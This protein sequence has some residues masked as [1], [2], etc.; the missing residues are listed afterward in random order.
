MT[1]PVGR[2]C[3]T[4]AR[5]LCLTA[6]TAAAGAAFSAVEA[7]PEVRAPASGILAVAYT[8]A[9]PTDAATG[10]CVF[11]GATPDRGAVPAT[12]V[13][14]ALPPTGAVLVV[15]ETG[16]QGDANTGDGLCDRDAGTAGNQCTL[17]AAIQQANTIAG[18][19]TIQFSIGSGPQTITPFG[20]YPDITSPVLIDG[21][22]QPGFAGTPIVELNGTFVTGSNGL[23]VNVGGST[24]TGL[25]INRFGGTGI[26]LLTVGGNT[27]VGNYI[28]TDITGTVD[29]GNGGN[30]VYVSASGNVVGGVT[31]A[32][33]NLI[34]GNQAAAVVLLTG[35]GAPNNNTIQGNYTGTDVTGTLPLGNLNAGILIINGANNLIG[36]TAGTSTTSC[37][38]ACNLVADTRVNASVGPC[39]VS[40][41]IFG[42]AATGNR[43]EGNYVGTDVTGSVAMGSAACDGVRLDQASG[44]TVG[45]TSPGARNII[46]DHPGHGVEIRGVGGNNNLVQGNYIGTDDT[47]MVAL[48]NAGN[49][50]SINATSGN[51]I[52]GSV[53]TARNI[54]SGNTLAGVRIAG[55]GATGNNVQANYIG[56]QPDGATALANAG[57]GV[58]ITDTASNNMIGGTVAGVA[59]R[60]AHNGGDG[61][62]IESGTGNGVRR[63]SIFANAGLGLDLG[64]DGELL[65]D[66]GDAD[67]GANNRQNYPILTN[68]S[69]PGP[70]P[71]LNGFLNSAPGTA[72]TIEFFSTDASE[73]SPLGE[74]H[75][76][77]DSLAVVTDGT[78]KASFSYALAVPVS[79]GEFVTATATDGAN[80]TSEISHDADMDALFD[81]WEVS[82]IDGNDNGTPDLILAGANPLHRDLYL[83]V[84]SMIERGIRQP[85]LARVVLAFAAA[86]QAFIHNPDQA[87]GVALHI[88]YDETNVTRFEFPNVWTEFNLIKA[89]ASTSIAGGFGTVTQRGDP[90][91]GA[92]LAAKKMAYRYAI[93][94]DK[95]GATASSGRAE[96]NGNDFMVTL[97]GWVKPGGTADQ[98]AGTFMHEFGHTLGLLHGGNQDGDAGNAVRWNYK[99]NYH[100]VMNYS[101]QTPDPDSV[102]WSLDYSRSVFPSLNEAALNEATGIGGHPGHNAPIGPVGLVRFV[103][104]SGPVD[105]SDDGDTADAG[106]VL[107]INDFDS[108]Y[109]ASPGDVLTGY[110]DWSNL[111]YFFRES[112]GFADGVNSPVQA[113]E[114][115]TDAF[116]SNEMEVL[117][118]ATLIDD[119][120]I[121][122][123]TP[124]GTVFGDVQLSGGNVIHTFTVTN[125]G[126][127][128]L[129]LT[130]SPAVQISGPNAGDFS[131]VQQPSITSLAP[132]ASTTFKVRFAPSVLGG[133]SATISMP[134]TDLDANP[135]D[136]AI[137][138]NGTP[139]LDPDG[140]GIFDAADNCP[141]NANPLQENSDRNFIDQT[142]PSTQDDRT[143][144]RSDPTGDACDTDD[145]NDGI[146][147]VDE[148]AGCNAS[149][150]LSPTNR[151][152]DGDR[153][154]DGAECTLAT[155]PASAASKPT[156]AA[157]AAFLG[158]GASVDTD[159]DRL[160][161]RVEY[162]AYN[163]DRLLLDTDGDQ[164]AS[165]LNAN[166]AV[167]LIKDGCEAA[168]LNN[169]RVVNS[170]DQ[171]L[172]ALEITREID[173]TLRLVSMDINKDGGVNSG[174]QL[175]MVGFIT[176]LGSCP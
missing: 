85:T 46:A 148:A 105:W 41:V 50:V 95:H 129:V 23:R 12:A 109:P 75:F 91:A 108:D 162:C 80:N 111:N 142:P 175:L 10:D 100:S 2:R 52:G 88:E 62:W 93:I 149:G 132:G 43:V 37:T 40:V 30:G 107:D 84:D 166:P 139:A 115:L 110:E 83:E 36:G 160:F 79:S 3:V 24:V 65:N 154:L 150:P 72:F 176:V 78:G 96:I 44:T 172:I 42:A 14:Q 98:Q 159:G 71:T 77:L 145:D 120:D 101:W 90:N 35:F 161:D 47:G 58:Y 126:N 39:A 99:P 49:G 128:G 170:A 33:R 114:E 112:T 4:G 51:T 152:T 158:V 140:D 138:G 104:E 173:Q 117:G 45:G 63:N 121:A 106:V 70:G 74:G 113:D 29:L 5:L 15:N 171:L 19:D 131:V 16:D 82:G 102:G 116:I 164:D 118:N 165:P 163:T 34:S 141:N 119:G 92:I 86:P 135:Y 87:N 76:Y 27:I 9:C 133:R 6:L 20:A 130:G 146:L 69:G 13:T 73:T 125:A 56:L 48:P 32:E 167:N 1:W 89:N 168:S 147:D 67:G 134:S 97:G 17:R 66:P 57:P 157:C 60:I 53:N 155:N 38:G 153:V 54:I 127:Y 144:P 137:A 59:N 8:D 55:A 124:D 26:V 61:V 22:T 21:T 25:V 31:P 136:F 123:S 28:G 174:D 143:W 64:A 7:R 156:A 151:D 94:G 169:D 68:Y 81:S 18:T 11:A 122:A 103:P